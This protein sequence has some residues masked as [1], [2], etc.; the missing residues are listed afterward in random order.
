MANVNTI[1]YQYD[2][3]ILWISINRVEKRNAFDAVLLDELWQTIQMGIDEP[4]IK[5]L[6]LKAEGEYFS[7]G[8]DLNTMKK[9]AT[10]NFDENLNNAKQLADVLLG[11]YQCPKPT[12]TIVQGNAYGG[13]LGFIA[14]S[15]YVI[16]QEQAQFCFSEVRLGLIPAV[17]SPYIIE[18]MGYK[19]CKKLF[20]NAQNFN[21]VEALNFQLVDEVMPAYELEA[22]SE[23]ILENWVALPQNALQSI[24]PWLHDIHHQKIDETMA[25]KTAEKLA[26]IRATSEAQ[27]HLQQFLQSK[28]K[29]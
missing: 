10:Q 24:K 9:L 23:R 15:D 27:F 20:L 19:A 6:C 12:L 16:T 2:Q 5:A 7:A 17:I 1:E 28:S 3:H 18:T 14:A 29:G 8:A 4:D 22:R 13:A 25:H 21:A 11:W 26:K